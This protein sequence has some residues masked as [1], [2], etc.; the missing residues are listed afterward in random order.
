VETLVL[1]T[2]VVALAEIGDKTQLLAIVLATRFRQPVPIIL[3][4]L[5]ATVANHLLAA[6]GGFYLSRVLGGTWFQLVIASSFIAMA[7]WTLV[8]D[9]A[10]GEVRGGSRSGAYAAT[11][12]AFFFVE[13]GD[14]TQIA[15]IALAARF[16][17]IFLVATGTTLGML[18]ADVPAVLLADRVIKIIP[19]AY[20]R[21]TA[22]LLF[23]VL[24]AWGLFEPWVR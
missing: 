6:A 24:G 15:T 11:L 9:N 13:V 3:G 18:L 1:S 20:V 8:P 19:I 4:I 14:K 7:V 10:A 17:D 16:H 23:F 22:A 2:F 12:V 21:T 5:S